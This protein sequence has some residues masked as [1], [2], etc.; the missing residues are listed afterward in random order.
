MSSN[1]AIWVE[2]QGKENNSNNNSKDII[3]HVAGKTSV[4][5][6]PGFLWNF[7]SKR[8]TNN[9]RLINYMEHTLYKYK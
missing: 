8:D 9:G 6:F 1:K 2:L 5:C 4:K 7:Y 3:V